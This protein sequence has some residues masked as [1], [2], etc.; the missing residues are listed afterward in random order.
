MLFVIIAVVILLIIATKALWQW[1]LGT[2]VLIKESKKQTA[3]LSK[4]LKAINK[5]D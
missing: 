3:L 4:I 5:K 1:V 2:D